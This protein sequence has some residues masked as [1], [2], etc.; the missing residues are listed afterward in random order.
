MLAIAKR[1]LSVLP[2]LAPVHRSEAE[3]ESV[4]RKPLQ[5]R[6]EA[7]IRPLGAQLQRMLPGRV[8]IKTGGR[9]NALDLVDE[10]IAFGRMQVAA[11]RVGSKRPTDLAGLL[12]GRNGQRA[13]EEA[14]QR[15]CADRGARDRPRPIE[16]FVGRRW[17]CVIRL[18]TRQGDE[19]RPLVASKRIGLVRP[20]QAAERA[21]IP[22][23]V[24]LGL[25]VVAHDRAQGIAWLR[26]LNRVFLRRIVHA[27]HLPILRT[28]DLWA[29]SPSRR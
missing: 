5:E 22:E 28:A 3:Q 8:V 20:V 11:R 21:R 2:G 18:Q 10:Q 1:S 13:L 23:E 7:A 19:R 27:L 14:R 26:A 15:E 6:P 9:G 12:P 4:G 24:M 25:L 17:R 29:Q 16:V